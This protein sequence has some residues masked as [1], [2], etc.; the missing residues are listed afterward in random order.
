[1]HL[2][3]RKRLNL[4]HFMTVLAPS[5]AASSWGQC[6]GSGSAPPLTH[7]HVSLGAVGDVL[8]HLRTEVAR[9]ADTRTCHV[10]VIHVLSDTEVTCN[11]TYVRSDVRVRT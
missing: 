2:Q 1:M 7:P 3:L 5:V 4:A 9:R 11:T 6:A 10:D 8:A